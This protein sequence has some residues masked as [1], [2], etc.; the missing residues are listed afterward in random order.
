LV[1][2]FGRVEGGQGNDL[3]HDGRVEDLRL[4]QLLDVRLGDPPLLHVRVKDHGPVLRSDIGSLAVQLRWIVSHFEEHLQQLPVREFARVIGDLDRLDMACLAG[5]DYVI[6]S[7]GRISTGVSRDYLIHTCNLPK[8]GFHAP[9]TAPRQHCRL[10]P[11]QEIP[12]QTLVV[13]RRVGKVCC[14]QSRGG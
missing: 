3:R 9:E 7:G 8:D 11:L 13:Y 14:V 2:L 1:V 5:A 4:I 6:V 12:D 10:I